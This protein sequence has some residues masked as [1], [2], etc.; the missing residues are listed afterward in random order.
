MKRKAAFLWLLAVLAAGSVH[1]GRAQEKSAE[2]SLSQIAKL[3]AAERQKRLEEGARAEAAVKFYSSE[4]IDLLKLLAEGFMKRYPFVK[5][6]FWRR[7]ESR[8]ID[9]VLLESRA[10]TLDADVVHAP[11]E[12]GGLMK[13]E[14]VWARY[15]SPES[16]NY[17]KTL[18]DG[19]GYWHSPYMNLSVIAYDTKQVKAQ[20][21][22]KNYRDLL[23]SKW[24]GELSIDIE[25][26]RAVLGWLVAWGEEK[27]RDFLRG[28]VRNGVVVRRGHTQQTQLLCGG[29]FKI[30]IEL[31]AYEVAQ[32]KHE[33]NCAISAVF[34]NPTPGS[35][36]NVSGIARAA[37]RPHAAAL[38]SDFV[39]SEEGAKIFATAGYIPGH[40]GVKALYEELS[41]LEQ[42]GISMLIV[43]PERAEELGKVAQKMIAE[44][45]VRKQF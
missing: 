8:L 23:H 28:L 41:Q 39:L 18:Y 30:A 15:A 35:P 2:D 45:L 25:P 12:A 44:L 42:K 6:E 33:K 3:P 32:F 29:E 17:A 34:P 10:G 21:A 43:S 37:P 16:R 1:D 31:Y 14:R 5:A 38:F 11:F 19:A 7:S 40:K 24:K 36:G 22:P 20:E 26:E 27:T 4:S 13:K 9:R